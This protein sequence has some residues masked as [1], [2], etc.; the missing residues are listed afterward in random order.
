MKVAIY[1]R[2]V[3][4][5][6]NNVLKDFFRILKDRGLEVC[7]Y[8]PFLEHLQHDHGIT[9]H[10]NIGFS[11]ANSLPSDANM[12]FSIG[13]DGT[14]LD[15]VSMVR[16]KGIPIVGINIG[17]LGFL[18]NIATD[19]LPDAMDMLIGGNYNIQERR[20]LKID[21]A[22]FFDEFP[23]GLND[24][25]I[26]KKSSEMITVKTFI[27]EE[28]LNTYWADGLIIA[29]PTGS[30]AYSLSV[31]G[32]IVLPTSGNFTISPISAH[33]LTVRPVVVPD[34]TT[35]KLQ[36]EGD[37]H[38]FISLD[39]RVQQIKGKMEIVLKKSEFAVKLVQLENASYYKTL[40]NKLMWGFDKRN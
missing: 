39:H 37:P 23:Y 22:G 14:I 17:K 26:Q 8:Q 24:F 15:A 32:P 6:Y 34:S 21:T 19:E 33:N 16:D 4:E 38:F 3:K 11:D 35:V 12:L 40:R 20:L 1:G 9:V 5:K 30:T 10:G 18:A 29:T 27:D 25:T 28:F 13:G 36:V 7:A 31:G 2:V